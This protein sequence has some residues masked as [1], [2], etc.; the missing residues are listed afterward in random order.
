[1]VLNTHDPAWSHRDVLTTVVPAFI[2]VWTVCYDLFRSI[3]IPVFVRKSCRWLACPFQNFIHLEDLEETPVPVPPALKPSHLTVHAFALLS[4]LGTLGKISR[5]VSDVLR[6]RPYAGDLVPSLGWAY[7]TY[8]MWRRPPSTPPYLLLFFY[9]LNLVASAVDVVMIISTKDTHPTSL[10][11]GVMDLLI[12][13]SLIYIIGTLPIKNYLPG[14]CVASGKEVSRV[15]SAP[16]HP[17]KLT[18]E[19]LRSR[20]TWKLCRKT[21]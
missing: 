8:R 21:L 18:L 7:A 9:T 13:L 14:P 15:L 1:M 17:V 4:L 16:R 3:W 5:L 12:P 10:A 20:P 6:G 2:I 11:L 19:A